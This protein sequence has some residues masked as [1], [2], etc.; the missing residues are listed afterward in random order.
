M[1]DGFT[2]T[3]WRRYGKDRV[4]LRSADG[5]DLG[6]VDLVGKAVFPAEPQHEVAL[7]ECLARWGAESST[8][9]VAEGAVVEVA[10]DKTADATEVPDQAP[11]PRAPR[12]LVENW[13]GAAARAKRDEINAEAPVRNLVARVLGVRT[14]ERSWRVGAKGE[15]KVAEQLAKLGE[16]WHRIHA[17]PVGENDSD[18]D[19]VVIGPAGVFTLNAKRHPGARA[20]VAD[21]VVMVNGSKTDYLRNSRFE[22]TRASK[23][24]T[25]ACGFEV[26]AKPVIVFVDLD[27]ITVKSMPTD[28]YVTNRRRLVKW[29]K[30]LPTALEPDMVE[31]IFGVARLSNT[32]QP[33]PPPA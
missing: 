20:W 2:E 18:I 13:A 10:H 14:E 24:L 27:D 19:H 3:R 7:V 29:F 32:W 22:G 33:E 31:Q 17:V 25:A 1:T 6:Y 5:V 26:T 21:R 15:E 28:V 9:Q 8:E 11:A 16:G 23:L 4:Y 12:D 30:S